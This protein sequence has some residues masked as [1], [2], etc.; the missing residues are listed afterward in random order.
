VSRLILEVIVQSLA[1]AREAARGGADRLEIVRE[2]SI[3]G[4][5]PQ[6]S[7]VREIGGETS[8]PS[9]VMLRENT[10]YAT[11]PE[12]SSRLRADA[13]DIVE[14][15]V[16]GLVVGFVTNTGTPALED[17]RR[18]LSAVPGARATFH[19]AFDA[20]VDPLGAIDAIRDVP[21]IDRILTSGGGGSPAERCARLRAFSDRAGARMRII[22]GGGVTAAMLPVIVDAHCVMEVHVGRAARDGVDPDAPVSADSVRRLRDLLDAAPR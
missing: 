22:A 1:D 8:L 14:A 21:E 6:M 11:T 16:D 12:E 17:L 3:G 19:R 20:L 10:G 13:A 4:L 7:L 9:R 5:T 18:I 2:I 15:G